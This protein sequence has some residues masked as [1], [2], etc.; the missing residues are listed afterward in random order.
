MA[1]PVKHGFF[2]LKPSVPMPDAILLKQVILS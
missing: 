2:L 1:T